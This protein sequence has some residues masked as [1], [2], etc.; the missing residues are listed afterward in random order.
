MHVQG[1]I[2]IYHKSDVLTQ[3]SFIFNTELASALIQTV[4]HCNFKGFAFIKLTAWSVFYN[5]VL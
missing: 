3:R 2:C 4:G 1:V 5:Q